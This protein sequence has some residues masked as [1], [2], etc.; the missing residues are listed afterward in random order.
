MDKK[1]DYQ[2][3]REILIAYL[4]AKVHIGDWHGVSDAANDLRVLE[5]L[6]EGKTQGALI[7]SGPTYFSPP[8]NCG[9]VYG[10]LHKPLC[11]YHIPPPKDFMP[12]NK[13]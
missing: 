13:E 7:A 11:P 1:P 2:E 3:Q 4:M 6:E 9:A 10:E 12:C 5:A 8:C